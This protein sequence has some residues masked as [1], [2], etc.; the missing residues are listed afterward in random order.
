[1]RIAMY[2][3][4]VNPVVESLGIA[5]VLL[6][7]IMGGYLVLGQHTPHPRHQD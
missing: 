4:L 5:M 2:N 1:M 6:A 3:S 7:A